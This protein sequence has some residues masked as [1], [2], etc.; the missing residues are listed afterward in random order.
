MSDASHAAAG[1]TI[2]AEVRIAASP[3]AVYAAW[4]DP[5]RLSQWFVD[6]ASGEARAG[7]TQLWTWEE[8]GMEVAYDIVVAEP[9]RRLVLRAPPHVAPPGVIELTIRREQGETVLTIVNSGFLDGVEWDELVE[10]VRSGWVLA[11]AILKE[12]LEQYAGR[13]KRTFVHMQP[14]PIDFATLPQWFNDASYLRRWLTRSG[15]PGDS[16][17]FPLVLHDGTCVDA[18]VLARTG[19]ELALAL[20]GEAA[21]LEL[22][23]FSIPVAPAATD[24]D[25]PALL[26]AATET[27]RILCLR[28][29]SWSDDPTR[30]AW[31]SDVAAVALDRLVTEVRV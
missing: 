24:D 20:R 26:R 21:V 7:G 25:V 13:A 2:E 30:F 12:Y 31:L 22:K 27:Q 5:E 17:F 8:F 28:G 23:A 14:A 15:A 29:T 10:G 3:E 9:G 6:R 18:R 1:R 16:A 19:R 11:L 4:A